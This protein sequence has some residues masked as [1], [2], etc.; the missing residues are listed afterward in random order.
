MRLRSMSFYVFSSIMVDFP[1]RWGATQNVSF[2]N[3]GGVLPLLKPCPG[4]VQ[5]VLVFVSGG[6]VPT[7]KL[8]SR[9]TSAPDSVIDFI[10][11]G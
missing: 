7:L 3:S 9:D 10:F 11:W 6:V 1:E 2:F 5:N 4:A 8:K